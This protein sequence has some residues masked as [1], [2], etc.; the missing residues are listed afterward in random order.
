MKTQQII[1]NFFKPYFEKYPEMNSLWF[2]IYNFEDGIYLDDA[3]CGINGSRRDDLDDPKLMDASFKI[4]DAISILNK[5]QMVDSQI[6]NEL[7]SL[8]RKLQ[9][10]AADSNPLNKIIDD[11]WG[12]ENRE[13]LTQKIAKR[14]SKEIP[15]KYVDWCQ[16]DVKRD[17]TVNI[18][19]YES[20]HR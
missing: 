3:D 18:E 4:Q 11:V 14:L 13:K 17:G 5:T 12:D 15:W 19:E 16:C 9:E 7:E 6:I 10:K 20:P 8:W 2:L 1:S